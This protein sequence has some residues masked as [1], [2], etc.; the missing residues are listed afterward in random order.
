MRD[1]KIMAASLVRSEGVSRSRDRVQGGRACYCSRNSREVAV[2]IFVP[3]LEFNNP[4]S[5]VLWLRRIVLR[6]CLPDQNFQSHR[7]LYSLDEIGS[8][9]S[10]RKRAVDNE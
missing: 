7:Y 9:D 10:F 4:M 8:K 2:F 3:Y 1:E 6:L 5:S